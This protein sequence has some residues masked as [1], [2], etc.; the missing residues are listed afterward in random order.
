MAASSLGI[1]GPFLQIIV[2]P[3][4]LFLIALAF[5]YEWFDRKVY[6]RFQNRVG[7]LYT[8]VSG[9]LQPFADFIKLL[10]KED[11]TPIHA[12]RAFFTAMPILSVATILTATVFIPVTSYSGIVSFKG[13]LIV[14]IALLT[15]YCIILFLSGTFS[16]DR[17]SSVGA[18]RVVTQLLG[19]EIPMTLA[20]V[21]VAISAGSLTLSEIVRVQSSNSWFILFPEIIGFIVFLVAAQAELERIPFDIP[22][23]ETEIVAGWQTEYSGRKLA[24]F[25]LSIDLEL[26]YMSG[27]AVTLFLGGPS[28]PGWLEFSPILPAVYFVIKTLAVL[29]VFSAVRALFARLRIDQMVSFSWKYLIPLSL[30]QLIIVK[31]VV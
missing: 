8:G 21:S 15:I 22:E 19:Y 9:F 7:P 20:V 12:D 30:L 3:G 2:F 29:V 16:L 4:I 18:E 26:V 27:L 1:L 13:D 14:A 24:L 5:F 31:V 28:G 6:A 23:A 25:R 11:I 17:F 10:S